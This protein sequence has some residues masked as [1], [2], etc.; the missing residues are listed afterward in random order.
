MPIFTPSELRAHLKR[1]RE[2]ARSAIFNL[3]SDGPYIL[4]VGAPQTLLQ[5]LVRTDM[6]AHGGKQENRI[7][8]TLFFG[9]M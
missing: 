2:E 8:T 6:N 7:H 3:S 4:P 1:C 9:G 5:A